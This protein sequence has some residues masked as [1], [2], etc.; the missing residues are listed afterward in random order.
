MAEMS[1]SGVLDQR[2]MGCHE[3]IGCTLVMSRLSVIWER[4]DAK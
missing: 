1:N 3:Y 4:A 2:R